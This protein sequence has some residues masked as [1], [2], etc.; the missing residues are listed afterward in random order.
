MNVTP[1]LDSG[2]MGMESLAPRSDV[3]EQQVKN[4][5]QPPE[6]TLIK[7]KQPAK[8]LTCVRTVRR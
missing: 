6:G 3:V 2:E 1:C 4:A 7:K 8:A 5:T